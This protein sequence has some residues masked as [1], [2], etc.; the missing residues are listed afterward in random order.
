MYINNQR[1][2]ERITTKLR[3][4]EVAA[5]VARTLVQD[6]D[7]IEYTDDYILSQCFSV[8]NDYD[9]SREDIIEL[10][11]EIFTMLNNLVFKA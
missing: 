1:T 3:V 5:Y 9:L 11:E 6:M 8:M 7:I 10:R 4:L 2:L